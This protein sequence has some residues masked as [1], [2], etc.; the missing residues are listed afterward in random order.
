MNQNS[1]RF[2]K[3]IQLR[4][5][6]GT[7]KGAKINEYLLEKSRVSHQDSG[8]RNFHVFYYMLFGCPAEERE[9]YG[10]LQPSMYRYI[11]EG[12]EKSYSGHWADRYQ[13]L[14][15]AMRMVGFQAQEELDL[16]TILSG[17]LSLGNIMFVTQEAG[18]VSVDGEACGW[19]KAAAG[20][21][22]VQE[23]DLHNCLVCTLSVTRGE[24]I[25]RLH[26]QQQAED[27][28]DSI[29]RVVYSRMFGWIVT[30][31]NELL[32]GDVHCGA[33]VQEIGILDIFGFENFAVNRFE[34]L[35]INLAN[36][37][38][39]N[40]Y[41]HHIFLMEQNHYLQEGIQQD[42]VTFSNNQP[43][44][45]LFLARP[46]GIL[47]ILDEQT[48]FPQAS[49]MTF[50]EKL[51]VGCKTNLHF[52]RARGKDPGFII[53]HYAGKVQYTAVGFLEKNRDTVPMNIQYLFINSV[54]SLLSLLFAA[55]ISRTGTL[56]PAQRAKA[57]ILQETA[58]SRKMSVGAQF[59]R[60]LGVLM[61]KMNSARPHFIRCIKPNN[62]KLPGVF[63]PEEVLRQLRYNGLMETLRIR[64]DGFSWRPSFQEFVDRYGVLLLTPQVAVSKER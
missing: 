58:T 60:S 18:G 7:V 13:T 57:Q 42:A 28:R 63:H 20:Q 46:L 61:E 23:E 30:K 15:N 54:T 51:D 53:H 64:R 10:L 27:A 9:V 11:G 31:V 40:F 4:F 48:S 6:Q 33:T 37:Q 45:D 49:D 41:N 55:S 39:Q 43:I 59:R 21:F 1:S 38:L 62:E 52:E 25:R 24:T 35:C 36:E 50:V 16:K 3:Y 5:S 8:E 2:G 14:C 19:L 12:L 47:S 32:A 29:A 56:T 44:L 34:Q 17:V 22:G 26:T